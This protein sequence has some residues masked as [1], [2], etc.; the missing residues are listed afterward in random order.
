MSLVAILVPLLALV[1]VVR[2]VWVLPLLGIANAGALLLGGQDRLRE[3]V[4]VLAVCFTVAPVVFLSRYQSETHYER[5]RFSVAFLALS[6][7]ILLV[8]ARVQMDV[9]IGVPLAAQVRVIGAGVFLS[10]VCTLVIGL[11]AVVGYRGM[12]WQWL[13]LQIS[14]QGAL[15]LA[16]AA[17]KNVLVGVAVLVG[18]VVLFQGGLCLHR[19]LPSASALIG[20]YRESYGWQNGDDENAYYG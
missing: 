7:M 11:V 16:V 2:G 18:S 13:G 6:F 5:S 19:I 4:A 3:S 9:Q 17:Q 15:F 8:L 12:V 10:G 1:A 20:G 14:V